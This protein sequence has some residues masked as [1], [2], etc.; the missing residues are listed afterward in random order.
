MLSRMIERPDPSELL[1]SS[2]DRRR[3]GLEPPHL[4]AALTRVR[5][6]Y[7]RTA[8]TE[9][10]ASDLYR[11]RIL[12]TAEAR[13]GE[14][15][16]SHASAAELWGCPLLRADAALVHVTRPG[17]AR[18]TTAAVQ[19]HRGVIPDGHV[20]EHPT[21]HLVTS[22][23]WTA[24]Q[25]A[26]AL[27]L[28]NVLLPLDHL[29][30]LLNEAPED[31]PAGAA[32]RERL[33]ALV[34]PQMRGGARA[35]EH[36]RLADARSGSAGESL[37]RGQ[38]RLIGVPMPDLQ[39]RFPRGDQPG[40]DVVDFDWPQLDRF[41]EFDGKGKY[42]RTELTGGRSA[43]DVLWDE[44]VREDRIR[45]HRSQAARWGWDVALSRSRLARVLA[46]AGIHPITGR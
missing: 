9:L 20:V 23:E 7:Y 4:D 38:M 8:A 1:V 17:R 33:I 19:S 40:E 5:R 41:G 46:D 13:H 6:G 11:L 39:V 32:V 24:V 29:V 28:P 42:F 27:P 15:V 44:K 25:L 2:R 12:A 31:D 34:L 45:R 16:F 14:I 26:A 43:Q 21:G 10:T 35:V 3:E 37:S 36:L 22:R 30:R 18:R